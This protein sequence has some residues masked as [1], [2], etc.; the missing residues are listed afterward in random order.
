MDAPNVCGRGA[1]Q[2]DLLGVGLCVC[3]LHRPPRIDH[4][5]P[6]KQLHGR[7]EGGS[8][9]GVRLVRIFG[10]ESRWTRDL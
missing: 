4:Y 10:G 1:T 5:S 8:G 6:G 3:L 9:T 7:S 2:S